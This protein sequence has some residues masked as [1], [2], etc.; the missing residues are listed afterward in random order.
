[1]ALSATQ[2][3]DARVGALADVVSDL[4]TVDGA[5]VRFA[6]LHVGLDHRY[7]VDD[8]AHPLVGRRMP[9]LDLT[10]ADGPLRAFTLLHAARPV[11]LNLGTPGS[12]TARGWAGRVR[13][14][15]AAYQGVWELPVVGAVAAP[16]AVLI[17]PDGH[18]AW[19]G[20]GTDTG[21]ED[22]LR[23]WFGAPVTGS[24][25]PDIGDQ[26]PSGGES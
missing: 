14:V 13:V 25:W 17:R 8:G 12:V 16:A 18:V 5:R 2:R 4:L 6:S 7:P 15:D 24:A 26:Q 20:D 22:T 19:A 11:L 23:R 9:D 1:M 3:A 21:L 10:S